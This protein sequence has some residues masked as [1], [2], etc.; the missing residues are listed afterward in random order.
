MCLFKSQI[1][2]SQSAV[3]N[4]LWGCQPQLVHLSY[5]YTQRLGSISEEGTEG[6]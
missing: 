3:N 2:T 1:A 4:G 6:L 5:I